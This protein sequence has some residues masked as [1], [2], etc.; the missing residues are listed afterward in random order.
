MKDAIIPIGVVATDIQRAEPFLIN[1]FK[2]KLFNDDYRNNIEIGWAARA[3]S[4]APTFFPPVRLKRFE[5]N[6]E[7]SRKRIT[8]PDVEIHEHGNYFRDEIILEDGGLT[9]NN[10]SLIAYEYAVSCIKAKGQNPADYRFQIVSIST[11]SSSGKEE[12]PTLKMKYWNKE[13]TGTGKIDAIG[14]LFF[15]D[16]LNRKKR[17]YGTY[18]KTFKRFDCKEGPGSDFFRV[19]FVVTKYQ[20]SNMDD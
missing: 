1:S 3:T 4:A 20:K 8:S 16:M 17:K 9:A 19:Q 11:G 13:D 14:R 12:D 6:E 15:D 5:N 18:L 10:P 7:E 2:A